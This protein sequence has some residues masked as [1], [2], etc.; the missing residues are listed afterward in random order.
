MD[1]LRSNLI[2]IATSLPAGSEDRKAVLALLKGEDPGQEILEK[3]EA[4]KREAA[5][6][7]DLIRVAATLEAGSDER[8]K[9]LAILKEAEESEA[10]DAEAA[11]DRAQADQAKAQ[12]EEEEA[13][14]DEVKEASAKNAGKK[15]DGESKGDQSKTHTDY[16][17]AKDGDKETGHGESAGDQSKSDEDY[18]GK[19]ATL[20]RVAATLKEGTAE[21]TAVLKLIAG[22]EKLPKALQQNCEDMKAGKEPEKGKSDKKD[23]KK[24]DDGKMPAELLEKFK[25]KK[26]S[27]VRHDDSAHNQMFGPG[28]TGY[29]APGSFGTIPGKK[30]LGRGRNGYIAHYKR[31]RV[32][33]M[34]NTSLEAQEIAAKHFRARKPYDVSV[35]LVEKSG[36]QVT[37]KTH[38]M[39]ASEY[40][41]TL[42]KAASLLPVGSDERKTLLTSVKTADNWIQDAIKRPGRLHKFFGIPEG[43]DIPVAKIKGEI[44]K[45]KKKEE[46]TPE[47]KSLMGALQLG[48]RLK[49]MK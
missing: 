13:E 24:K 20:E 27:S 44:E 18:E 49:A 40:R 45:L 2:K 47:D 19:K 12:A 34:A 33:V 30:T 25:A 36:K 14:A 11:E 42:I 3:R 8:R 23:D 32:D 43:K 48:L 9:L 26:K 16:A 1:Q 39:F 21:H 4:A 5:L 10:Q 38:E 46:K 22:C 35:V 28:G 17:D 29:R 7:S 15:D 37:H 31:K 41:S 6:R